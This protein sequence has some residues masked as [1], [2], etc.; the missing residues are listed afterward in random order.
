MI[1]VFK[2]EQTDKMNDNKVIELRCKKCNKHFMDYMIQFDDTAV[3][4][5]S[6]SIKCDRCKRVMTLKKYTEG[7]LISHSKKGSFKM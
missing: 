4:M 3:V 5:Q 6:I 7:Y 2:K 1:F